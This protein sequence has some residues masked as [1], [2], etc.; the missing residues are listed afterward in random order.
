[1][2]IWPSARRL[3]SF[4]SKRLNRNECFFFSL[5]VTVGDDSVLKVFEPTTASTYSEVQINELRGEMFAVDTNS[6]DLVAY[7]GASKQIYLQKVKRAELSE[8]DAAGYL[9]EF[10]GEPSLAMNF[11]SAVT[12]V[13]F[14]SGKYL[15][16]VSEDR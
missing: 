6:V 3:P 13:C 10:D 11:Q 2:S 5:L 15:L 16:G 8:G 14:A 4:R 7:G 1:M 12:K 9:L